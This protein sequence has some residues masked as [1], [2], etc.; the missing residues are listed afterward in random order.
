MIF[1]S[2]SNSSLSVMKGLAENGTQLVTEVYDL[3]NSSTT[4]ASGAIN[5]LDEFGYVENYVVGSVYLFMAASGFLLNLLTLN[6]V[7]QGSN[8]NKEVKIQILNLAV[9]DILTTLFGA[10][11]IIMEDLYIP[12]P[13]NTSL[14][15]F[16][17]FM[18]HSSHYVSLLCNATIS[19]ERFM[20]IY[21]PFRASHYKSRHKVVVVV[22]AWLAGSLPA[23]YPALTVDVVNEYGL[24]VCRDNAPLDLETY[25]LLIWMWCLKYFIPTFVIVTSYT[26][27]FMRMCANKIE[28]RK[29]NMSKQWSKDLDKVRHSLFV[30]FYHIG[31]RIMFY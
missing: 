7:S 6:I 22:L 18:E 29:R 25:Q 17:V 15:K 10:T 14:C 3:M 21:F 2:F 28:G 11:R 12:F 19:I 31:S 1:T 30:K 27:V 16:L 8:V 13:V 20:I 5:E 9:A 4:D 26:L 23:I 24:N